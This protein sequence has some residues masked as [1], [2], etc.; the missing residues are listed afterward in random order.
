[1]RVDDNDKGALLG[2][3]AGIGLGT[4]AWS[5][6]NIGIGLLSVLMIIASIAWLGVI[7]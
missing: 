1:M 7:V 5:A 6:G 3:L 4:W 2:L